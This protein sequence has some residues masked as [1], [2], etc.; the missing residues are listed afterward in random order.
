MF[1]R[2]ID[3]KTNNIAINHDL[4][5]ADNVSN[6]DENPKLTASNFDVSSGAEIVS[7]GAEVVSD[8]GD[9]G[10]DTSGKVSGGSNNPCFLTTPRTR[11]G[12]RDVA[13][14]KIRSD[15]VKKI[16]QDEVVKIVKVQIE[17]RLQDVVV[18]VVKAQ[19]EEQLRIYEE[20]ETSEGNLQEVETVH[21]Q[22]QISTCK[23]SEKV[24]GESE[25][26]QPIVY[27]SL[28]LLFVSSIGY[29]I[30]SSFKKPNSKVLKIGE[31]I[32]QTFIEWLSNIYFSSFFY[33][34]C[35]LFSKMT[36]DNF[37]RPIMP[38]LL[39]ENPVNTISLAIIFNGMLLILDGYITASLKNPLQSLAMKLENSGLSKEEKK[40][41]QNKTQE[42]NEFFKETLKKFG[43]LVISVMIVDLLKEKAGYLVWSYTIPLGLASIRNVFLYKKFSEISDELDRKR[44][45]RKKG[46]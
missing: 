34:I 1:K 14:E 10:K 40:P 37:I 43:I 13:I 12:F 22:E 16:L 11:V 44:T 2:E 3:I 36:V 45:T 30:H 33:L 39:K 18:E 25:F 15:K 27:S 32:K 17:E 41:L 24:A 35:Y 5:V 28:G 4:T 31:E 29:R 42:N 21:S 46:Q 20:S 8:K 26:K 7:S 23:G 38:I 9:K 19:I 6:E